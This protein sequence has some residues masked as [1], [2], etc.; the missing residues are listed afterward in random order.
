MTVRGWLSGTRSWW[1][2]WSGSSAANQRRTSSTV[3]WRVGRVPLLVDRR[4]AARA[5]RAAAELLR[6]PGGGGEAVGVAALD[7]GHDRRVLRHLPAVDPVDRPVVDLLVHLVHGRAVVRAD[8][9][10]DHRLAPDAE[11][12]GVLGRCGMD[13][14][15]AV[16]RRREVVALEDDPVDVGD[17]EVVVRR[18]DLGDDL[19]LRRGVARAP[20]RAPSSARSSAGRSRVISSTVAA[21]E[22][23]I[24]TR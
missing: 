12:P 24:R 15:G 13:V 2:G 1:A 14:D 7:D 17:D 23:R 21:S 4:V 19:G 9:A 5:V 10:G 3:W 22:V 6:D 8:A 11:R 16:R 18:L 20:S